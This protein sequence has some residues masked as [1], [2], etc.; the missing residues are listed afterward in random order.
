MNTLARLI[1]DD[2]VQMKNLAELKL[3]LERRIA[4]L[5]EHVRIFE[6]QDLAAARA[7][8]VRHGGI[9]T[10]QA[11]RNL[12]DR[13]DYAEAKL[14]SSREAALK[15]NSELLLAALLATLM[16]T[17]SILITLFLTIRREIIARSQTE[18][19]LRA[20]EENLSVT[21]NSI[22]DAVLVTDAA[23][24]VTSLNPIAE[25][26]TGWTR[27]ESAGRPV[28]DVFH[29]INL[30][31]RQLAPIPVAAVLA[32]GVI[33]GLAND[34]VLIARDGNEYSIADSC[35]PIRN[36]DGDIIGAVLYS[37]MYPGN[38]AQSHWG[39]RGTVSDAVWSHEKGSARSTALD[40]AAK[41]V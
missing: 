21:L 41:A 17:V 24:R 34:T 12:T 5:A 4:L 3:L 8:I 23:G 13:M 11:I 15:R 32:Q 29:I 6:D 20:S 39:Q 35:A 2:P 14:L 28:A 26:L 40:P 37:S 36:R 19:Q 27:E 9:Q 10:M 7:A 30:K 1:V 16:L 33:Y 18:D 31:T 22:G 38:A 25:Q